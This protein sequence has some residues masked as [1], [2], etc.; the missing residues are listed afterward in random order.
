MAIERIDPELCNGCRMCVDSCP[1]DVVRMAEEDTKAI[2]KYPDDCTL[3][4][5]C[6][7]VCPEDAITVAPEKT[8]PLIV[9]WG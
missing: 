4:G 1:S 2:I 9:S 8:S 6:L 5:W 7:E 3:C